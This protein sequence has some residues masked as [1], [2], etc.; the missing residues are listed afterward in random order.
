MK[1]FKTII[2]NIK[3]LLFD[4]TGEREKALWNNRRIVNPNQKR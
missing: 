2:G 1:Y 4:K 3:Y